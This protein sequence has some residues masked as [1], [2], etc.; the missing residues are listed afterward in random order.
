VHRKLIALAFMTLL[1]L[2]AHNAPEAATL[3]Q[4]SPLCGVCLELDN[5]TLPD[6]HYFPRELPHALTS[7]ELNSAAPLYSS[8]IS[9]NVWAGDASHA[10]V[11]PP[12][13]AADLVESP[14]SARKKHSQ[15]SRNG[16]DLENEQW[17]W[18]GVKEC[19]NGPEG[20][21]SAGCH[22][23]PYDNLLCNSHY[24][25][26]DD[27]LFWIAESAVRGADVFTLLKLIH[28][29]GS[30]TVVL[31]KRRAAIQLIGC[32]GDVVGHFPINIT[33]LR[34]LQ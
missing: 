13:A 26:C 3:A 8:T 12:N 21:I 30:S 4:N 31:N 11:H 25:D 1:S 2:S 24:D 22:A 33:L 14:G 27:E 5:E 29:T 17:A 15:L 32:S 16:G 19:S 34:A 18:G 7:T 10:H 6:K 28:Q 9:A 20:R 23:A